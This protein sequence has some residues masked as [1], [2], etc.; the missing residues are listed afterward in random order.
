[1]SAHVGWVFAL[2][3]RAEPCEKLHATD[4]SPS[5]A[6]THEPKLVLYALTEDKGERVRLDWKGQEPP[7]NMH[8]GCP[9]TALLGLG[10]EWAELDLLHETLSASTHPAGKHVGT[11]QFFNA[12]SHSRRKPS[13]FESETSQKASLGESNSTP[14]D[15]TERHRG[16][17]RALLLQKRDVLMLDVPPT[18]ARRCDVAVSKFEDHLRVKNIR[19]AD[20]LPNT[21]SRDS[22]RRFVCSKTV[23]NVMAAT[24]CAV[25]VF[26]RVYCIPVQT[27][28]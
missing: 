14:S 20:E 15:D 25:V 2:P 3:L 8:D 12:S 11:L 4:A 10:L 24:R 27:S 22:Q 6:G 9:A 1:M 21:I 5:G 16:P 23:L 26:K 17:K 19:G 28:S 18:A 13:Y 7:S